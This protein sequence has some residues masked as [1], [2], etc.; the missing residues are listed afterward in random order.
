MARGA[1]LRDDRQVAMATLEDVEDLEQVSVRVEHHR[2]SELRELLHR[3]TVLRVKHDQP[4]HEQQPCHSQPIG[5]LLIDCNLKLPSRHTSATQQR[6]DW[7][8]KAPLPE[9]PAMEPRI[10]C[11]HSN[12]RRIPK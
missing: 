3:A 8:A 6:K 9:Q 10:G 7:M 1:L 11:N 5:R 2:L 4:L 12:E